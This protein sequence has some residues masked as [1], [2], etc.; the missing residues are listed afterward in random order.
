MTDYD[1][2][3]DY[4]TKAECQAYIDGVLA[5]GVKEMSTW[6]VF[7]VGDKW[8]A[9]VVLNAITEEEEKKVKERIAKSIMEIESCK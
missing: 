8:R 9:V 5:V 7:Q 3:R 2:C 6:H 4:P 1:C